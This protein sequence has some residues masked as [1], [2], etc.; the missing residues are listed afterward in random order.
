MIKL[1]VF[2][3]GH[4]LGR[5]SGPGTELLTQLSPFP[6]SVLKEASRRFFHTN[7]VPT[8][9][10]V[11]NFCEAVHIDPARFPAS[12]D[13]GAFTPFPYAADA[14]TELVEATGAAAVVLSNIP[15]TTGPARM[16]SLTSH[17]PMIDRVYT[18][19]E[20]GARKPDRRLWWS[21]AANH[22]VE[23][24]EILHIGDEWISDVWGSVHAG[25]RAVFLA[26]TR[27]DNAAPPD[28]EWPSR[29]RVAIG[30]DL[31]DV[32]G[33]ALGMDGGS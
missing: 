32:L 11:E 9:E 4:T 24:G 19:Y 23:P 6:W 14:V 10:L 15:C 1:L 7:P 20:L 3:A 5:F 30:Q 12:W 17:F 28:E 33:A 18:S 26:G 31:T 29:D 8:R 16:R 22:G 2:D 25:C 13:G 21:I 27:S